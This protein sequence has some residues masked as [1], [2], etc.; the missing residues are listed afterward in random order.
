MRIMKWLLLI[1]VTPILLISASLPV[2]AA[3]GASVTVTARP[4][5]TGGIADFVITYISDTQLDISWTLT[6][7]ATNIMIR[8]KYGDY[9]ADIPNPATTPSDGY[10]VYY[11]NGNFV[12]D[13]SMNLDETAGVL[14]YKAWVQ[15][16]DDSWYIDTSTGEGEGVGMVLIALIILAM[17]F[18]IVSHIFKKGVLAFAG[19]GAWMVAAL[20][21]F[22]KSAETWDTYFSLAFLFI[23]LLIACM[24]SPLAWRETTMP[25]DRTEDPDIA[26]M[27]EEMTEFNKGRNQF[28]FLRND[29]RP[30][31]KTRW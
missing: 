28:S 15:K 11:D 22:S 26:A 1:I 17:G 27:R 25:G 7:D 9:P 23:G 3:T 14:Y 31:G 13:T 8:G 29:R 16:A 18:T 21:C 12:S 24:F 30:R 19:A 6:G 20:Y 5:I 2:L 4:L 10:L